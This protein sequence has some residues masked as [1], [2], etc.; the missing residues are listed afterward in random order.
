MKIIALI[1][2]YLQ[3]HLIYCQWIEEDSIHLIMVDYESYDSHYYVSSDGFEYYCGLSIES[4]DSNQQYK[5]IYYKRVDQTDI[6]YYKQ[7]N[8]KNG[9]YEIGFLRKR[10]IEMNNEFKECWCKDFFSMTFDENNVLINQV[11][12]NG[13]GI[14]KPQTFIVK[15]NE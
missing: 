5:T 10:N 13:D 7:T 2:F 11:F 14:S 3:F 1:L 9:S 15:E 8:T 4:D 6:R 12:Y